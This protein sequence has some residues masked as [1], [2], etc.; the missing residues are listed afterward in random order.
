MN[1]LCY[2]LNSNEA[3]KLKSNSFVQYNYFF[4][5]LFISAK[6]DKQS[7]SNLKMTDQTGTSIFRHF[8]KLWYNCL[9]YEEKTHMLLKLFWMLFL[10]LFS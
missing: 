10:W 6:S 2:A 9:Y 1:F 4:I 8:I 3:T 5:K 7:I